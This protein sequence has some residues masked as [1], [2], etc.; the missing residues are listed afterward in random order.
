MWWIPLFRALLALL[1]RTLRIEWEADD[2]ARK[3]L[4]SRGPFVLVFWHGS[5]LVPWWL[6]RRRHAAAVVSL[7][8]DGE[9]LARILAAWG[10]TVLRGSSSR[11]GKGVMESMRSVLR[12]GGIL[13]VTP[14][15]PRGPRHEMKMGAVRAAQTTGSPLLLVAVGASRAHALT[16]WDRFEI[17]FP[18]AR[19]R[20]H[21]ARVDRIDTALDGE[22]LEQCRRSLESMLREL[23]ERA[24]HRRG[25]S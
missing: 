8:R 2:E 15:G 17:P 21:L 16:S 10:Y 12:D 9:I 11:G 4:A 13:C 22:A 25:G 23:H 20:L 6:M 24:A 19:V 1:L 3:L 7:S 18:F 5:M 14:D